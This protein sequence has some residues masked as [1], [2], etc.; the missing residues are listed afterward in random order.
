[1]NAQIIS[2]GDELL[3]GQIVN[4]N[5][6]WMAQELNKLGITVTKISAV[7]DTNEGITDS[8][9]EA[10]NKVDFVFITGGLGPTKDDITKKVFSAFFETTLIINNEI[11]QDVQR[12]FSIRNKELTEINKQQALVPKNGITI[13]NKCG[14]APGMWVKKEKTTYISMPGVPYEMKEMML[15]SILPKIISE[16]TLPSIFHKTVL[17]SGIG[18]SALS[19]LIEN[20]EDNLNTQNIK[21]AYLPQPGMVRLRLSTK[22]ENKKELE[23]LINKNI[24]LLKTIIPEY[25]FGIE[26]YGSETSLMQEIVVEKLKTLNKTVSVAESCTGGYLSHLFTSVPGASAVFKSGVVSY[27]NELKTKL[28]NIEETIFSN[29]GAVSKECV[30]QLANNI[31]NITDS[32]FGIGISGIAGPSGGTEEKPVG[33][34]WLA[35]ATN[36]RTITKKFNFGGSRQF[37]II[38]SAQSALN[39]LRRLIE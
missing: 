38:M 31:K 10:L 12:F 18:E 11:L 25:I 17:T 15:E 30:T 8:F 34:V 7:P 27:S 14:T 13:R 6:V 9:L 4:T 33:T 29:Y 37:N 36:E 24:E 28:L 1:M 19:D 2:I 3:I 35:I 23:A 26:N 21:L 20:W 22:G 5:S 32:D 39:E 16:N